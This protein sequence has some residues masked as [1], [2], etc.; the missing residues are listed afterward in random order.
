MAFGGSLWVCGGA[1]ARGVLNDVWRSADGESWV[2]VSVA[3]GCVFE[4]G[5]SSVGGCIGCRC[6]LFFEEAEIVVSRPGGAD[7]GGD[8]GDAVDAAGD[9]GGSGRCGLRWLG[10]ML[11][12]RRWGADSGAVVVTSLLAGG[13]GDGV[14]FGDGCDAG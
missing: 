13:E 12:W 2:S 8:A 7:C 3:G 9:G 5:E 4:A 10:M 6:R 11:G 1:M 14:D